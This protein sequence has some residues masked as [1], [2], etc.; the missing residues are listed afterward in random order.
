[1]SIIDDPRIAR[2]LT[3]PEGSPAEWR[4]DLRRL[5]SADTA[6]SRESAGE[7]SIKAVQRLLIFLGYSTSTAGAFVID[8]DFGRGTN[9]AVAQ[10]QFEQGLNPNLQRSMLC[11]DCTWQTASKNI[12]AIPDTRLTFATLEKMLQTA[13]HMIATGTVMCGDFEEALF[14]LNGLHRGQ[15]LTCQEILERYGTLVNAAIQRV[16]SEQG[17]D[18]VPE[19]IL[20]IIKQETS[21]VVRPRFEQHYLSRFNQQ[22]PQTAFRELRHRA[23]SFGLGQIMGENY[24]RVGAPSAAAMF[25]SP[26]AEQVLFVARF[27]AQ[28]R[29]V[30]AKRHPGEADFHILSR[31]Y[32]GPGYA[33]HFYHESLATWF[34]EFRLLL[35]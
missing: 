2:I 3:L 34:K 29:E 5:E 20:A 35:G 22:E 26:L 13:L 24:W 17:F 33:S 31:F 25:I 11:Y 16:R 1:M 6:L 12:V 27:L 7:A 8:G 15:F 23:M 10:F 18:L 30:V 28:R 21:G 32:N 9:R 14:H 4:N 19:W